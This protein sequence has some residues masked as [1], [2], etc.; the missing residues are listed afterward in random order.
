MALFDEAA[1]NLYVKRNR[2]LGQLFFSCTVALRQAVSSAGAPSTHAAV[3]VFPD[4]DQCVYDGPIRMAR[5]GRPTD[6][7][8]GTFFAARIA[9]RHMRLLE[10]RAQRER[11]TLS[12]ALRRYLDEAAHATPVRT[13]PRA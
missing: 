4:R 1:E 3:G 13:K 8:K 11:I 2:R 5:L 12:E 10:R 7:P 6:D 9:P